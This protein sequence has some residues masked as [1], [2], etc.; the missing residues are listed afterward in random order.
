[1]AFSTHLSM[2]EEMPTYLYLYIYLFVI[3]IYLP[4]EEETATH[5]PILEEMA[6]STHLSM[7]EEVRT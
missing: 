6:F 1:M 5:L 7:L 2:L 4:I 3:S